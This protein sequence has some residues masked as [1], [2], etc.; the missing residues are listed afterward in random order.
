MPDEP[1]IDAGPAVRIPRA[2]LVF[3][4]TPA[5]GPG[6]QHVN[7]VATRI[8][9]WWNVAT[10]AALSE[11]QR[12]MVQDRL[13]GRI[14]G[15]GW[16]RIV[17]ADSRSQ[18]RNRETATARFGALVAAA[19]KPRKKRRPTRVSPAQ[20]RAR[21]EAKRRRSEAKRLRGRVRHDD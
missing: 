18:T 5:G 9:L 21:L 17:A 7:R 15:D 16:L 14:D 10:T 8:E 3:R 11:P 1:W 20:K 13:A 6:G 4:A 19:L 12:S 2:E